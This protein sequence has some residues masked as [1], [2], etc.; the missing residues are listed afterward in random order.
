M[1]LE[2]NRLSKGDEDMTAARIAEVRVYRTVDGEFV[3]EGDP[4]GAFLAYGIGAEIP[5]GDVKRYERFTAGQPQDALD[6]TTLGAKAYTDE[7][8]RDLLRRR[9]AGDVSVKT[10]LNETP[11]LVH[12]RLA[13]ELADEAQ[14]MASMSAED[15][16]AL[17]N[18]GSGDDVFAEHAV[19]RTEGGD[20]VH[21][22]D[23]N[24][25]TLAYA[26]GALID[27]ADVDEYNDLG[28]PPSSDPPKAA[29]PSANKQARKPANK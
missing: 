1:G 20:L 11:A 26:A 14:A 6:S 23:E 13:T 16:A 9:Q 5:S 8:T 18:E 27:D 24:G 7:E 3:G 2:I 21:E 12:D 28:A 29:T 22:G 17:R 19:W 25:V 10:P 4:R 15:L